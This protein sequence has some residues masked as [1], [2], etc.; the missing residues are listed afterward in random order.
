VIAGDM[1]RAYAD[2]AAAPTA[3]LLLLD[4]SIFGGDAGS[5][6]AA[7]LVRLL[8]PGAGSAI[9]PD[10]A[11][12]RVLRAN[13]RGELHDDPREAFIAGR[14]DREQLRQL[15]SALPEGYEL[16]RVR[17]DQV[18]AF[19]ALEVDLVR[20]F[21]SHTAFAE[22]G[23][24]FGVLHDGRFVAGCSSFAIGGGRLEIEIDTHPDFRRRG[25]ARAA[26]AAMVL[27]CLDHGLEPCWDAANPMSSALARQ[28][29][30]VS[31]GAYVAHR[32]H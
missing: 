9:V 20:N 3:A 10:E 32:L 15:S 5:S 12:R 8:E 23:V 6:G 14:F 31:T 27:W 1:G 11:W 26:G 18:A 29:G 25:L 2:A 21:G 13:Y 22:R 7:G 19:A 16:A 24:G 4:F 17:P 30:F 28:L